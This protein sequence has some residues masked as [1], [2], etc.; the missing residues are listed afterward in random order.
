[1]FSE[2]I[3]RGGLARLAVVATAR[4]AA[5]VFTLAMMVSPPKPPLAL[6]ASAGDVPSIAVVEPEDGTAVPFGTRLVLQAVATDAE[7]GSLTSKVRWRSNLDGNLGRGSPL[8]V[9]LSRGWHTLVADVADSTDTQARASIRVRI[10]S[11]PVVTVTAPAAATSVPAGTA[12]TLTATA[13]DR[14]DGDLGG[15]IQW[16]SDRD[17]ALGFGAS[18]TATLSEGTHLVTATAM[19]ADDTKE[20][21]RVTVTVTGSTPPSMSQ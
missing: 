18:I 16:S 9:P 20:S 6:A 1:M 7:D 17:G 21:A 12:L 14:E 15:G 5:A 8:T 10:T 11:P 3:R 2:A 4:V 19:D 13:I